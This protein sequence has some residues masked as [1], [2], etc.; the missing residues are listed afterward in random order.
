MPTLVT[1]ELDPEYVRWPAVCACCGG[2]DERDME[3]AVVSTSPDEPDHI[4]ECRVPYCLECYEHV[5]KRTPWWTIV[6]LVVLVAFVQFIVPASSPTLFA[7]MGVVDVLIIAG[8]VI[9][10]T[11]SAR[12]LMTRRCAGANSVV[13]FGH[14]T[15]SR[16]TTVIFKSD[17]YANRFRDLNRFSVVE[18]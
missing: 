15:S 1:V 7:A 3:V 13:V 12:R 17:D 10:L 14:P 2:P 6:A 8:Y 5:G 4:M 9:W 16:M 11:R 18:T